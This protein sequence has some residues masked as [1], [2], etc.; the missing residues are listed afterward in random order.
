M[1][2]AA[3]DLK[4]VTLELGGNDA[5]IVLDDV[6]PTKAAAALFQGAFYNSGQVCLA[7]KRVYVDDKIY[8]PLVEELAELAR[9]A[10]VGDGLDQGTQFGPLQNRMQYD[11]VCD[12][13]ED[14]RR[15][16]RIVAGGVL[17]EGP[18][19]FVPPTIVRDIEDGTRLVD[20]EQ[21]GPIL[22]IIRVQDEDDALR[23]ANASPYGLGGSVW[24]RDTTRAVSLA[25]RLESGTAWVNKHLDMGPDIPFAGAK[26]SGI[27]VENRLEGLHAFTQMHVINIAK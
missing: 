15:T 16:G 6:D 14:A 19:Y 21:F 22:P 18:G 8:E 26:S 2:S 1:A 24:S 25:A 4:R 5:A 7:V 23:R 11:R 3:D 17:P 13:L 20:E 9:N 10:I 12:L 27:G